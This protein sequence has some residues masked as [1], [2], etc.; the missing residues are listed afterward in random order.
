MFRGHSGCYMEGR[1]MES[2]E[3][4]LQELSGCDHVSNTGLGPSP[5]GAVG[6]A[7]MTDT[8]IDILSRVL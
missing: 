8:H 6:L 4:A 1:G 7:G 5:Q 3:E 2:S